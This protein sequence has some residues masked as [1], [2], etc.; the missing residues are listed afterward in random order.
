M[1]SRVHVHAW[2]S[3]AL[4][5]AFAPLRAE[6]ATTVAALLERY[7]KGE[8]IRVVVSRCG[9]DITVSQPP[10]TR[11][12]GRPRE[13]LVTAD[14][15]RADMARCGI[16]IASLEQKAQESVDW[17]GPKGRVYRNRE[18]TS[19][20]RPAAGPRKPHA[21]EARSSAAEK[22]EKRKAERDAKRKRREALKEE[23]AAA[24]VADRERREADLLKRKCEQAR[25][26]RDHY[27]DSVYEASY[28]KLRQR[29]RDLYEKERT[30]IRRN[31]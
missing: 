16:S 18:Y 3:I 29:Y 9:G 22:Q 27:Y 1:K 19:V 30:W 7:P 11:V 12:F 24:M 15:I 17:S 28:S 21:E 25:E 20:A 2:S 13:D 5:L 8:I 23:R 6:D 10:D 14:T 26:R 31:C 4:L